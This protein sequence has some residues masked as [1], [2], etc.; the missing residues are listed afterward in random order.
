M[1]RIRDLSIGV[2]V[3]VCGRHFQNEVPWGHIFLDFASVDKLEVDKP[4]GKL[5]QGAEHSFTENTWQGEKLRWQ[6]EDT[7][8]NRGWRK[9]ERKFIKKKN[10][11]KMAMESRKKYSKPEKTE[12][13]VRSSKSP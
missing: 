10:A 5:N 12:I 1:Q 13:D 6:L 11:R 9:T 8:R 3:H 7:Q 2:R 4:R